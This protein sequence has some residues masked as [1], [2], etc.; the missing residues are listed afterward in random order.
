[1]QGITDDTYC[2]CQ[3]I[4]RKSVKLITPR[5]V[6]RAIVMLLR[7]LRCLS[8]SM[9]TWHS[10]P[11]PP[12]LFVCLGGLRMAST[13]RHLFQHLFRDAVLTALVLEHLGAWEDPV[14]AM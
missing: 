4:F 1:M 11:P 12:W 9:D 3:C 7:Y 5:G 2:T 6:A 13:R 10:G 8:G 14:D